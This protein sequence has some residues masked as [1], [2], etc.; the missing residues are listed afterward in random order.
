MTE[1]LLNHRWA[2]KYRHYSK[3]TV[4]ILPFFFF[5]FTCMNLLRNVWMRGN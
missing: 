1:Q 5:F 3:I 4:T 2:S